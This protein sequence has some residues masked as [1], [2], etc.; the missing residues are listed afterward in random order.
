[1]DSPL[2][3]IKIGEVTA[4]WARHIGVKTNYF[5]TIEST[6]LQAKKNA[7]NEEELENDCLL[8][9]TD[10]QNHGR[11]R[12]EHT[13]ISPA[14]G[15]SLMATWSFYTT[16]TPSPYLTLK[17]GM[18]LLN[19]LKST[20]Q[21]LPFYLKAPN[22]I[23]IKDK[24]LAGVLIETVSQGVDHRLLV[25]VGL[26]VL[27][28]PNSIKESTSIIKNMPSSVPL[29]GEDWISFCDRFFFEMT[30]LIPRSHENLTETEKENLL[31]L[32]NSFPCLGQKYTNITDLIE[33][34]HNQI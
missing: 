4:Q 30:N 33:K 20:W 32:L 28:S 3:D 6:N 5:P 1:M 19:S 13:W 9:I 18:A 34:V 26:N 16:E 24:K 23:Y 31:H 15:S 29:L 10:F 8:Y 27:S 22:D 2:N 11:G 25:G 14:A 12:F 17:V 7:F 21:F